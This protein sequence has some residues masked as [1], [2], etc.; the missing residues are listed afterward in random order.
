MRFR[1]AVR[2]FLTHGLVA[3][4]VGVPAMAT[5]AVPAE[6]AS[7]RRPVVLELF[8]SEG[9]SSCPPADALLR[10]FAESRVDVLPLAFHVTYWDYLGWR[11][12]F[13]LPIATE[14]QRAYDARLPGGTVYTPQLV[15]D[16]TREAVG[17]ERGAVLTAIDRALPSAREEVSLSIRRANESV[18]I[19]VGA[20]SG[21][22]TV[23][24]VSY[25]RVHRT[26]VGRGEN[27]GRTLVEANVVRSFASAAQ[28]R[29]GPL[30]A[31]VPLPQGETLAAFV[32]APDGRILAVAISDAH[33]V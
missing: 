30:Q 6:P 15:I 3:M 7:G 19:D 1:P 24:V 23:Y 4:A 32:Q 29:G 13:A 22:G 12:P 18:V 11:D 9:C 10:E 33:P 27:G 14:R 31:H 25:D 17:S 21:L 5:G 2:G 20:G 8:T 16:G 28:W 26:A